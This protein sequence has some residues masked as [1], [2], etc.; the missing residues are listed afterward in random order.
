MGYF[1]EHVVVSEV[2]FNVIKKETFMSNKKQIVSH[3]KAECPFAI[4]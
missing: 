4:D 3:F 1:C 2:P